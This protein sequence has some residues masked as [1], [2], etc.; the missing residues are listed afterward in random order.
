MVTPNGP[1]PPPP[2]ATEAG[3]AVTAT[4]QSRSS[5]MVSAATR[6]VDPAVHEEVERHGHGGVGHP[7]R[8][9]TPGEVVEAVRVVVEVV[10][11][12]V[13]LPAA[14]GVQEVVTADVVGHDPG[15]RTTATRIQHASGG[16]RDRAAVVERPSVAQPVVDIVGGHEEE[17][18]GLAA[19]DI[20]DANVLAGLDT[21]RST[22]ARCNDVI[23][24][25]RWHGRRV[26]PAPVEL[27]HFLG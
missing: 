25:H 3:H 15:E 13:H 11:H 10:L 6:F 9:Q 21:P 27:L 2:L 22:G 17:I 1:P 18:A 23:D 20:D 12:L 8:P 24:V 19:L 14:R 7:E 26:L 4:K 16:E 5:R